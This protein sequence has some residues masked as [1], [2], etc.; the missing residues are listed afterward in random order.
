MYEIVCALPLRI[1]RIYVTFVC[2]THPGEEE[3]QC[4][5]LLLLSL[6]DIEQGQLIVEPLVCVCVCDFLGSGQRIVRV[7]RVSVPV[8]PVPVPVPVRPPGRA[9]GARAV[10]G[11]LDTVFST[12]SRALMCMR[13]SLSLSS[14]IPC[15][16]LN[17]LNCICVNFA[18]L[19]FPLFPFSLF[20]CDV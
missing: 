2:I 4:L 5:G 7:V 9:C 12:L 20:R 8:P 1:Q 3:D 19:P 6:N 17:F 18:L 11:L 15:S 16:F 14:P 13:L 10:G